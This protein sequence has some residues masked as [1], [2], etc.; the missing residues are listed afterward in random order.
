MNIIVEGAKFKL[1]LDEIKT[2]EPEFSWEYG[3]RFILYEDNDTTHS[4]PFRLRYNDLIQSALSATFDEDCAPEEVHEIYTNLKLLKSIGYPHQDALCVSIIIWVKQLFGNIFQDKLLEAFENKISGLNLEVISEESINFESTSSLFFDEQEGISSNLIS[5]LN[6]EELIQFFDESIG[7]AAVEQDIKLELLEIFFP[8]GDDESSSFTDA[9]CSLIRKFLEK[10][11]SFVSKSTLQC[12]FL[13]AFKVICPLRRSMPFEKRIE[14]FEA[15]LSKKGFEN[16]FS[17]HSMTYDKEK[18]CLKVQSK[19]VQELIGHFSPDIKDDMTSLT[20][21]SDH[22]LIIFDFLTKN[23][24]KPQHEQFSLHESFLKA[25][26]VICPTITFMTLDE[27]VE[28]FRALTSS[29]EPYFDSDLKCINSSS[30]KIFLNKKGE[31]ER[32][33]SCRKL[34]SQLIYCY[35]PTSITSIFEELFDSKLDLEERD[36]LLS[37][38]TELTIIWDHLNFSK[39][40]SESQPWNKFHF[41]CPLSLIRKWPKGERLELINLVNRW[42][43][44]DQKVNSEYMKIPQYPIWGNGWDEK[45]HFCG[46]RREAIKILLD[47]PQPDRDASE[48]EIRKLEEKYC[49]LNQGNSTEF[50]EWISTLPPRDKFFTLQTI[51]QLLDQFGQG[52]KEFPNNNLGALFGKKD[53]LQAY[54]SVFN[55]RILNALRPLYEKRLEWS[56]IPFI[57]FL[58]P[59]RAIELLILLRCIDDENLLATDYSLDKLEQVFQYAN[60]ILFNSESNYSAYLNKNYKKSPESNDEKIFQVDIFEGKMAITKMLLDSHLGLFEGIA[61]KKWIVSATNSLLVGDKMKCSMVKSDVL[62]IPKS[63]NFEL[64]E[65][66]KPIF[67]FPFKN[68][69]LLRCMNAFPKRKQ[70]AIISYLIAAQDQGTLMAEIGQFAYFKFISLASQ[71]I[72]FDYLKIDIHIDAMTKILLEAAVDWPENAPKDS[73]LKK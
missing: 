59:Q 41:E 2:L 12:N 62:N 8:N 39:R 25:L 61:D 35:T 21:T 70:K 14:L 37:T 42:V 54:F 1:T 73:E 46:Y 68:S 28:L 3:R 9:H 65:F 13:H 16:K 20:I 72:S 30:F 67:N 48:L 47:I 63:E 18:F 7:D 5:K 27:R 23:Y 15:L 36:E 71:F 6:S 10:D 57:K 64:L 50:S 60:E 22:F 40:G 45:T 29:W 52:D 44:E 4:Q 11:P 31:E 66:L 34:F 58:A 33:E 51:N 56:I 49:F 69:D 19:T 32:A 38:L 24:G 55:E 26:K 17:S 53:P 43:K